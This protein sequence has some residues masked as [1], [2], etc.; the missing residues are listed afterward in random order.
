MKL[1]DLQMIP[2]VKAFLCPQCSTVSNCQRCPLDNS[3]TL[4]L[5]IVLG[6]KTKPFRMN[7]VLSPKAGER[8]F[9]A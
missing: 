7:R 6:D 2:L 5:A 9:E 3:E 1:R 4:V 8:R